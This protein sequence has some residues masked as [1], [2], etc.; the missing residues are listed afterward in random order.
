MHPFSLTFLL[1]MAFTTTVFAQD[2][3]DSDRGTNATSVK[4]KTF[5]DLVDAL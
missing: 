5:N 2:G 4:I 1:V 3:L